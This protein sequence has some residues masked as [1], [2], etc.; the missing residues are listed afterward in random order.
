M[1]EPLSTVE[2]SLAKAY[3]DIENAV[4]DMR[5]A[6][7][8]M[9]AVASDAIEPDRREMEK[10]LKERMP[11]LTGHR[12][13]VLTEDQDDALRYALHHVGDLAR[14]LHRTY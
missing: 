14:T 3:R 6:V 12:L 2:A 7:L 13:L 4:A 8:T 11:G 5:L 9:E 1:T 10:L